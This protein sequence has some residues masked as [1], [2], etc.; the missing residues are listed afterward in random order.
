MYFFIPLLIII[1]IKV[2]MI[3]HKNPSMIKSETDL[4]SYEEGVMK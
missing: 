1:G 2:L 3:N 4:K